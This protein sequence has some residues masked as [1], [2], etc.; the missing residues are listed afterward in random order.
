MP[1]REGVSAGLAG[2]IFFDN[3]LKHPQRHNFWNIAWI[4]IPDA[5]VRLDCG[6]TAPGCPF[7]GGIRFSKMPRAGGE[8][9]GV[10]IDHRG[11]LRA[12]PGSLE[13][14]IAVR[15]VQ[16]RFNPGFSDDHGQIASTP[17]E[18]GAQQ[19][20]FWPSG[21]WRI[22]SHGRKTTNTATPGQP[23]QQRFGLII[24]MVGSCDSGQAVL[25]GPLTE[26]RIA[27]LPCALLQGRPWPQCNCQSGVLNAKL[28]T[29]PA[30]IARLCCTL[31]P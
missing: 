16:Y 17:A 4:P 15:G 18:Q 21:Q 25:N 13:P 22:R 27:G 9:Q 24:C 7:N 10:E 14:V 28:F 5:A 12:H 8:G 29:Q 20:A 23:H 31:R 30:D 19:R 2:T 6:E 26:R 3:P 1:S 11:Q